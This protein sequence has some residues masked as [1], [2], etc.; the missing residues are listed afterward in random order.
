LLR[1]LADVLLGC[2]AFP[3]HVAYPMLDIQVY[4][5]GGCH[6]VKALFQPVHGE[7]VISN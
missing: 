5:T 2:F 3:I 7:F 6:E 1:G 4:Q